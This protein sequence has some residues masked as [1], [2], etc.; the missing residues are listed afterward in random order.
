MNLIRLIPY[1]NNSG[2]RNEILVLKKGGV[3]ATSNLLLQFDV[4]NIDGNFKFWNYYMFFLKRRDCLIHAMLYHSITLASIFSLL[5]FNKKIIWNI[6]SSNYFAEGNGVLIKT[7]GIINILFSYFVPKKIIYNSFNSL[8]NHSIFYRRD[9]SLVIQN[10]IS[11]LPFLDFPKCNEYFVFG[12]LGRYHRVKNQDQLLLSI[13]K[14]IK[15]LRARKIRVL[16]Q[17]DGFMNSSF[18]RFIHDNNID[19]TVF[20]ENH[21]YELKNF[22]SKINLLLLPSSKESFPTVVLESLA[23]G[24]PVVS[25]NVGD[26][27]NIKSNCIKVIDEIDTDILLCEAIKIYDTK[28]N[29]V[30]LGISSCRQYVINEFSFD[31][32]SNKYLKLFNDLE[33]I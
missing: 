33:K 28:I 15:D 16:F 6:R 24:R 5:T 3:L 27:K 25:N 10:G 1:F 13:Y 23:Y 26:V 7:L 8:A 12:C 30:Y 20:V 21:C 19:D 9:V 32:V 11:S 2:I 14:Y 22:F 31:N 17:G 4:Y 18:T 29:E